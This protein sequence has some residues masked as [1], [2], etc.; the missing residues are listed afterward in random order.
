MR[1]LHGR[2]LLRRAL[3]N[4][5]PSVYTPFRSQIDDPIGSLDDIQVVLDHHHCVAVI[6]QPVQ[7]VEQLLD[8]VEVQAGGRL[9]EDVEGVAG[10]ALG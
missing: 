4:D 8:I 2:D 10:V 9:V 7:H 6:A 5:L 3:G 1:R